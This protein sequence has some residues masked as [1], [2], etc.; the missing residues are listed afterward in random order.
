MAPNGGTVT[1]TITVTIRASEVPVTVDNVGSVTPGAGTECVDGQPTCDGED[2]LTATPET[3][4]A[5][6][7]QVPGS[8]HTGQGGADHLHR[9]GHQHQRSSRPPTPPSTIRSRRRSSPTGPGRRPPPVRAPP[10]RPER[11]RPASPPVV[12][13]GHRPG[14]HGDLHH[15]RP[16]ADTLRRDSGHQH[17]H[18]HPGDQHR[19]RRR[20]VDLPGRGQLHQPG[21]AGRGEDPHAHRSRPGRRVSRSPTR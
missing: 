6:D 19:L 11:R 16:V 21:P 14:R 17:R 4:P 18:R 10:R 3:G 13:A 9:G 20:P 1:F 15:H 5:H 7:R 12:V 2:T 8:D